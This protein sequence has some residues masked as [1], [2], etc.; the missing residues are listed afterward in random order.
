MN[1]KQ[2]IDSGIVE[3]KES[4]EVFLKSNGKQ[5]RPKNNGNGYLRIYI[6]QI[7]KRFL[8]HRLVATA[9]IPNPHNK[10]QVNHIDGNK[11]NN[12]ASNLEWC[13]NKEN[14][15][16][17]HKTMNGKSFKVD[18]YSSDYRTGKKMIV[19]K[20]ESNEKGVY[21]KIFRY[22]Y[23][24]DLTIMAFEKLCGLSN[25]SVSKWKN[26]GYPSI[27]TLQKISAATGIPIEKWL[28]ES[29]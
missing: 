3:I 10:P 13:T 14:L 26:G 20:Y 24:N 16:H 9:C 27:F 1:E 6:P 15:D 22:C 28:A 19:S 11:H 7:K 4:G 8:L 12:S 21:G 18:N 25:G 2:L 17:F 23:E 29:E 5:I